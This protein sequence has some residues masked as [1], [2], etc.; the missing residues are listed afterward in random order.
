MSEHPQRGV[1]ASASSG[2]IGKLNL[3][4]PS[5]GGGIKGLSVSAT[6]REVPTGGNN[7]KGGGGGRLGDEYDEGDHAFNPRLATTMPSDLGRWRSG[8]SF[9]FVDVLS[10]LSGDKAAAALPGGGLPG[11]GLAG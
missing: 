10:A 11:G 5:K 1:S 6:I 9:E 7:N 4:P 3:N 8:G 2:S